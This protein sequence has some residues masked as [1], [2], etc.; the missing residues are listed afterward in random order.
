[1]GGD[2][3][4]DTAS[5]AAAS[6]VPPSDYEVRHHD[7]RTR[8]EVARSLAAGSTASNSLERVSVTGRSD[9]GV[10]GGVNPPAEDGGV[11]ENAGFQEE[12]GGDV[13]PD[14]PSQ[15][16]SEKALSQYAD[17]ASMSV[18]DMDQDVSSKKNVKIQH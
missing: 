16:S 9:P 12:L 3:V 7:V 8:E 1:M 11:Y 6:V 4:D 14:Q 17:T 13:S 18:G 2:Q 15:T 5:E 10:P